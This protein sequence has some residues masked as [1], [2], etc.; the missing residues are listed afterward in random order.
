M[1][2]LQGL[3]ILDRSAFELVYGPQ[4]QQDIARWVEM[5]A[6]PRTRQ[7]IAADASLL[8]AAEVIFTGWGGPLID[9]RFL[10]AAPRLKAIFHGAGAAGPIL[11]DAVWARGIEVT[12]AYAANAVPVAE[13]TLATILF[14]LKHGWQLARQVREERA[15][16]DRHGHAGPGC[17]GSAIGLVSMGMV[18]RTLLRMLEPFELRVLAYDPFLTDGEAQALGVERVSLDELFRTS[19]V[20]SLHTPLLPET[21]GLITGEHVASM[22]PGATLINTARGQIIRERQMLDVLAR[23]PDLQ[24]VLDVAEREPPDRNSPLYTL[25][26]VVLTP[27]LA[28]S[29]GA[30]CRRMGRYMVDELQRYVSGKPLKWAVT[31]ELARW[32]THRP[33]TRRAARLPA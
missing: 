16:P 12:T 33:K 13:Y 2:R 9:E 8:A 11:T 29:I 7:S 24:A 27:H 6:P 23:R 32:T 4:E 18:A 17:Y 31:P 1:K 5:V 10:Q 26:N 21:R 30:E 20:V 22:R 15:F 25:P 3:Y 14:S 28:G 19:D